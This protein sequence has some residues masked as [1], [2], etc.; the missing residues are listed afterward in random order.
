MRKT[1]SSVPSRSATASTI[2]AN[3]GWTRIWARVFLAWMMPWVMIRWTW[4]AVSPPA[5][6]L[7][8]AGTSQPAGCGVPAWS[9]TLRGSTG[10]SVPFTVPKPR[11]L[12]TLNSVCTPSGPACG[13]KLCSAMPPRLIRAA[14]LT[15]LTNAWACCSVNGA[16]SGTFRPPDRLMMSCGASVRSSVSGIGRTG[17]FTMSPKGL[18]KGV[19]VPG[20]ATGSSVVSAITSAS[21]ARGALS[22]LVRVWFALATNACSKVA[23]PNSGVPGRPGKKTPMPPISSSLP[24]R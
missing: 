24:A 9:R 21:S 4:A 2:L 11:A 12:M 19:T 14:A 18:T 13:P 10:W 22:R 20:I 16:G 8:V 3:V 1:P 23:V 7:E 15:R 5:K 6:L 17:G